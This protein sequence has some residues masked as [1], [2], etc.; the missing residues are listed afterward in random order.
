MYRPYLL[1]ER[2]SNFDNLLRGLL[3]TGGR[4]SQHSYNYLVGFIAVLHFVFQHNYSIRVPRRMQ[5]SNFMF[6]PDNSA[7]GTDLLAYDIQR[8]RDTGLPPYNRIREMCG[9]PVAESFND[10]ADVIQS[11][12]SKYMCISFWLSYFLGN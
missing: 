2:S 5:I 12:V 9:L 10:L 8:G 3:Y 7:I 4:F 6:H 11:D 1:Q